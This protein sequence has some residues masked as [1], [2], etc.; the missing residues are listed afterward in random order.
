[1]R[2]NRQNYHPKPRK[3][4][5]RGPVSM[6][7]PVDPPLRGE[8]LNGL[9]FQNASSARDDLPVSFSP[10]PQPLNQI[11]VRAPKI[12]QRP[13]HPSIRSVEAAVCEMWTLG[14]FRIRSGR[15]GTACPLLVISPLT[16]NIKKNLVDI[17]GDGHGPVH[18]C[19]RVSHRERLHRGPSLPCLAVSRTEHIYKSLITVIT[20]CSSM[21]LF[22]FHAS[23]RPSSPPPAPASLPSSWVWTRRRRGGR[24]R[25]RCVKFLCCL[26]P[27]AKVPRNHHVQ[28]IT[29][30]SPSPPENPR[31]PQRSPGGGSLHRTDHHA[32]VE[33]LPRGKQ[34]FASVNFGAPC[35]WASQAQGCPSPAS[36][37]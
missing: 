12:P 18:P 26:N 2:R 13:C 24:Q 10:L 6:F 30:S 23:R 17:S 5:P 4:I 1:M 20:I 16:P 11:P 29:I 36:G 19:H 21:S 27:S 22:H 8:P 32:R 25:R 34:G 7:R 15:A 9:A 31:P 14:D 3:D 33:N 35:A 37:P 28:T